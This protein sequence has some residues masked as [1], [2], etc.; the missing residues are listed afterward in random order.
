MGRRFHVLITSD[1]S[2]LDSRRAYQCMKFLVELALENS[3]VVDGL[4]HFPE[5]WGPAVEWLQSLLEASAP[6][7][8]ATAS[9]LSDSIDGPANG[10]RRSGTF[11]SAAPAGTAGKGIMKSGSHEEDSWALKRTSSAQATLTEAARMLA[12]M[13]GY[14]LRRL[15]T[16]NE[17]DPDS[18]ESISPP[19]PPS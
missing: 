10:R 18:P 4:S 12:T 13:P 6:V 19:P 3:A 7:S 5:L 1:C 2:S 15:Q 11:G 17:V 14:D 8:R 16:H 9:V